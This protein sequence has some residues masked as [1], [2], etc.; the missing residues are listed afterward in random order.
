MWVEDLRLCGAT[1][2]ALDDEAAVTKFAESVLVGTS[3]DLSGVDF[4]FL[5]LWVEKAIDEGFLVGEQQ[6]AFGIHVEAPNWI[7][8]GGEAEV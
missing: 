5:L 8:A 1:A 4:G 7:D 2:M 6:K 3:F